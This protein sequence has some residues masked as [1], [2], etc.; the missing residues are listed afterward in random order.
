MLPRSLSLSHSLARHTVDKIWYA[1]IKDKKKSKLKGSFY[2]CLTTEEIH[3]YKINNM[4]EH[5]KR[6]SSSSDTS[7]KDTVEQAKTTIGTTANTA[8]D[9][10]ESTTA[11]TTANTTKTNGPSSLMASL[12]KQTSVTRADLSAQENTL[13]V[14]RFPFSLIRAFGHQSNNLF[15]EL[16]RSSDIGSCELWF[17]LRDCDTSSHIHTLVVNATTAAMNNNEFRGRSNSENNRLFRNK[18][19][20]KSASDKQPMNAT[21]S[22]SISQSNTSTSI[23]QL[24]STA[25]NSKSSC[26]LKFNPTSIHKLIGSSDSHGKLKADKESSTE[27][28]ASTIAYTSVAYTLP[29]SHLRSRSTSESSSSQGALLAQKGFQNLCKAKQLLNSQ[30]SNPKR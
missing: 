20:N 17:E 15:I 14:H 4:K 21:N 16:G 10:A 25:P 23:N 7:S 11:G 24:S 22:L 9:T 28:V 30:S 29:S 8:A 26:S 5:I 27:Y 12:S 13:E 3:L 19:R 18:T 2:L 6:L 1:V